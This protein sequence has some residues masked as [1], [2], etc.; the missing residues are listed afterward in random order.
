MEVMRPSEILGP[1]AP[2]AEDPRRWLRVLLR[3]LLVLANVV[4]AA[5][6]LGVALR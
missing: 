3:A 6:L 5:I 2:S 4:G 1:P